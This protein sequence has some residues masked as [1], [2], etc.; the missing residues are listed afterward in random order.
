M[1]WNVSLRCILPL[2]I[3]NYYL[4]FLQVSP[5]LLFIHTVLF[6]LYNVEMAVDIVVQMVLLF[7]GVACTGIGEIL[8]VRSVQNI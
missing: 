5:L 6:P 4:K 7:V 2:K 1:L 3:E 8:S